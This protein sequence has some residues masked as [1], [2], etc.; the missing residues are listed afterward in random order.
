M[1][2]QIASAYGVLFE[3]LKFQHFFPI[4]EEALG[5]YWAKKLGFRPKYE[6]LTVQHL[7]AVVERGTWFEPPQRA[8]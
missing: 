7:A 8:A 3:S 5:A 4:E 1:L 6:P 2:E